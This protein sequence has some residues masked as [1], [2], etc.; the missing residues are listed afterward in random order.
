[1]NFCVLDENG[2]E[3]V[4]LNGPFQYSHSNYNSFYYFF[5]SNV[6]HSNYNP[7]HNFQ[8]NTHIQIGE[9]NG[10][11]L[12]LLLL[13]M[14]FNKKANNPWVGFCNYVNYARLVGLGGNA[15]SLISDARSFSLFSCISDCSSYSTVLII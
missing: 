15:T 4:F 2:G 14:G 9:T 6:F 8:S 5:H 7:F 1:M 10:L 12:L 13:I 3:E 11:L